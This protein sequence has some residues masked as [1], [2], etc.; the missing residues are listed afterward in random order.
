MS[1]HEQRDREVIE[2]E[3][4]LLSRNTLLGPHSSKARGGRLDR[5]AYVL[6]SRINA[7]GPMTIKELH[8]AFGLDQSTLNRQTAA[9]VSSGF[10]EK[11]EDP[12]GKTAKRFEMTQLGKE[13]LAADQN[14]KIKGLGKALAGWDQRDVALLGSLLQRLN[15][16]IEQIDGRPWPR[17]GQSVSAD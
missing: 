11:T 6:L 17:T 14:E 5:S 4:M 9:M 13:A 16:G 3:T 1:T 15:E 10:V 2:R 8:Q 7:Q 12:E